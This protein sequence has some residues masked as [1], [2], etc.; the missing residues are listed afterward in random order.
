MLIRLMRI[1]SKPPSPPPPP[2]LRASARARC[3]SESMAFQNISRQQMDS[4]SRRRAGRVALPGAG[5]AYSSCSPSSP[6]RSTSSASSSAFALVRD[7]PRAVRVIKFMAF[8]TQPSPSSELALVRGDWRPRVARS[9]T[10][11]ALQGSTTSTSSSAFALVQACPRA[12]RV[13]KFTAFQTQLS[14]SNELQRSPFTRI[15][16]TIFTCRVPRSDLH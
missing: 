1:L 2:A 6:S 5:V 4:L 8:Q 11:A 12:V 14:P 13:I 7:R 3:V 16:A 9:C 10:P 15:L